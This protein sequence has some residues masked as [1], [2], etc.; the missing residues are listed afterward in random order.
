MPKWYNLQHR[1]HHMTQ[2]EQH[3]LRA[4]FP[5]PRQKKVVTSLDL[6]TIELFSC[7]IATQ[8]FVRFFGLNW[9]PAGL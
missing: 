6:Y 8:A 5:F 1:K 3:F 7:S 9:D 4:H 2:P